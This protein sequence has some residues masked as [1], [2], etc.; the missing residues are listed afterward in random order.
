MINLSKIEDTYK[1]I[2]KPNFNIKIN[3]KKLS[4]IEDKM[5]L[6]DLSVVVTSGYE[7]SICKAKISQR[8][9]KKGDD[10]SAGTIKSTFELGKKIEI[11]LGYGDDKTKTVF[12]GFITLIDMEIKDKT[13]ISYNIEAMDAK[14]LMMNNRKSELK[15]DVEKYSNVVSKTLNDYSSY[16]SKVT[17]QESKPITSQVQQYD[18]SDYHFVVDLAK[19]ENYLFYVVNGEA[20]FAPHGKNKEVILKMQ[21]CARLIYFKRQTSLNGQIKKVTVRSNNEKDPN[22]KIEASATTFK[23]VGDGSK[24]SSDLSSM[25]SDKN[26]IFIIDNS[27][28]SVD[29]AKVRAESELMRRS[30]LF[31]KGEF[32]SIGIPEVKPGYYIEVENMADMNGQYFISEVEHMFSLA[33]GYKINVK[34]EANKV[35][36]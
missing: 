3:D 26:E 13:I 20:I 30:L 14:F 16:F 11:L 17:V 5:V 29:E 10:L 27:I 36:T 24:S 32:E 12:I 15:K 6:D 23:S 21:P 33:Q 22:E 8:L 35:K 19:R 34:F 31:V 18:Q 25:I 7:A 4:L 2:T 1:E 28:K 9:E